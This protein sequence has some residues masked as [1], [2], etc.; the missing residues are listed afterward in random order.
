[1]PEPIEIGGIIAT[2][3]V[4]VSDIEFSSI[5]QPTFHLKY[6]NTVLHQKWQIISKG[7]VKEEWRPIPHEND[8]T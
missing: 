8:N 1:M 4:S 7:N 3:S 6:I 2:G 5:E